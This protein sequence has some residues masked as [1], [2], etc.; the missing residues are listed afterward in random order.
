MGA[1]GSAR[2]AAAVADTVAVATAPAAA[3]TTTAA[4]GKTAETA[5]TAATDHKADTVAKTRENKATGFNALDY[6]LE[7]RYLSRGDEFGGPWYSHLFVEAG[8][9]AEQLSAPADDYRF[10]T[11]TTVRMGVGK[12]LNR[13]HALRL[14]LY[15]GFGFQEST[16]MLL[17]K[18]GGRLDHLFNL[19]SYFDGYNPTRL[20]EVSSVLG[21]GGQMS[22]LRRNTGWKAAFEGHVGLQFRFYTGPRGSIAVEPYIGIGTDQGDVSE[23]RNWRKYDYFYG[24]TLNYVYYL[25][26]RMSPSRRRKLIDSRAE[27][28]RLNGDSTLQS[29]QQPWF[30]ELAAGPHIMDSPELGRASTLGHETALSVGKWLSPAIGVRLTASLR[31]ARYSKVAFES[32]SPSYGTHYERE[33]HKAYAG[34]RV[35]ALLNPLGFARSFAWDKPFGFYILL[36][37][38]LGRMVRYLPSE[39]LNCWSMAY[40][41]GLHLWARISDGVQ[42]FVEPRGSWY[43]YNIPYADVSNRSIRCT[44]GGMSVNVGLTVSTY[45]RRYRRAKAAEAPRGRITAGLGGGTSLVYRRDAVAG[46]GMDYNAQGW[47]EYGFNRV[48]ALRAAF[49]YVSLGTLHSTLFYDY[50]MDFPQDGFL[51]TQRTGVWHR[52]YSLGMVS[53][54]YAAN[55][56]EAMCGQRGR[57][58]FDVT[59]WAGPALVMLFGEKSELDGSER[60][61]EMHECRLA[62]PVGM[63]TMFGMHAGLR[64]T[65]N[66]TPRLGV[67]LS[68][69]VYV[70]S[71]GE[72][73][74]VAFMGT[75]HVETLNAGVQYNF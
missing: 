38:E 21:I 1:P 64:L 46:G 52:R 18:A 16:N 63:E 44:D 68:P 70:W 54:A 74:G 72:L 40:G 22:Q 66:V 43:V 26:D 71:K 55:L 34:A 39:T 50:N 42:A 15:A 13:L 31:S 19:S 61:Q 3:D 60:V 41:A 67:Y 47:A 73:P 59:A 14:S 28:D 45:D 51:R 4:A 57:R 2:T 27:G 53:L 36:G 56:T 33:Y 10:N 58:L 29:W 75:K 12:T 6:I 30:V 69:A 65:A 23:D 11:L 17:G 9:G 20:V 35:D 25:G 32:P 7:R 37:G 62:D 49:E 5:A 48:S 24:A 8:M